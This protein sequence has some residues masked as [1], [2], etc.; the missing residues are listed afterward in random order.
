MYL[1]GPVGATGS[2]LERDQSVR[3]TGIAGQRASRSGATDGYRVWPRDDAD[4]KVVSRPPQ[5]TPRPDEP[6]GPKPPRGG[7]R[8]RKVRI[9][10]AA[11][12]EEVT[13]VGTVTSPPGLI[14]SEG[15]RVTV[16]DGSGGILVRLPADTAPPTVG[17]QVQVSG[18]V[19]T[20]YDAP[21]LEAATM[22]RARERHDVKPAVLRRAPTE[23]DESR[24]VIVVVRV[25][26]VAKDGDTWRAEATLG[27]GGALPIAGLAGSRI[28]STALPEGRSATVTGI[29][30]RAHPAATDQRFAVVPRSK[31]DI[32]LGAAVA[33]DGGGRGADDGGADDGAG[34]DDGAASGGRRAGTGGDTPE[35][36]TFA[37]LAEHADR[38]VRVGGRLE[39]ADGPRLHLDDGTA[40]GIVRLPDDSTEFVSSLVVGEVVNVTGRVRGQD[41]QPP[42]VVARSLAD[43]QRAASL[44]DPLA[45]PALDPGDPVEMIAAGPDAPEAPA[46]ELD[47]GPEP[48]G[49]SPRTCRSRL[50][51]ALA[52]IVVTGLV[53]TV[54]GTGSSSGVVA[55][56]PSP[57]RAAAAGR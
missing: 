26:N 35:A 8:P 7:K 57:R 1:H 10:D 36:A 18:E 53:G 2:A 15:R 46:R 20:W 47:G 54:G 12:G 41:G 4:L 37:T 19:G 31:D 3:F 40:S 45:E 27:A 43:I 11:F 28:P 56:R 14:D 24:L 55:S 49:C 38:I 39:R 9:A 48:L 21:Q 32:R 34:P 23:A 42:E 33:G 17:R 30:R 6:G 52:A 44:P 5:V 16:E 22:P 51:A 50:L 29:V 25:E 13:I